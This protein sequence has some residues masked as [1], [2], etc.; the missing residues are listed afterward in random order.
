VQRFGG[1]EIRLM[2][3]WRNEKEGQP[4]FLS[5]FWVQSVRKSLIFVAR[6]CRAPNLQTQITNVGHQFTGH[7]TLSAIF[8]V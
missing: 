7:L 5:L 1:F 3:N 2:F 6:A 8:W 4:H